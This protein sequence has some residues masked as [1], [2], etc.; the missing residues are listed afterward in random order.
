[1]DRLDI[2]ILSTLQTDGRITNLR[3]AEIVGLSPTPCLQRVRRLE[4]KGYI[5]SYGA[6]LDLSKVGSYVTIFTDVVLTSRKLEV[7]QQFEK[8]ILREPNVL[9]CYILSG[10]LDYAIKSI[11]PFLSVYQDMMDELTR[12][13][14][15]MKY[16]TYVTLREVKMTNVVPVELI[17]GRLQ[18]EGGSSRSSNR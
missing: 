13:G 1:M 14:W 4:K 10:A 2:K 15:V 16:N 7:V 11:A 6:R 3:L 5:E 12:E 9:E 18:I 8:F 17:D